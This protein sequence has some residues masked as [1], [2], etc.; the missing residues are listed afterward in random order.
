MELRQ[1]RQREAEEHRRV[2]GD[3]QAADRHAGKADEGEAGDP[4]G[5]RPKSRR[6]ISA[7]TSAVQAW[8]SGSGSRIQKGASL[9]I[10]VESRRIQAISGGLE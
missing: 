6:A 4:A 10:A 5:A 3:Q 8:I 1:H 7:T 2:G 9:P